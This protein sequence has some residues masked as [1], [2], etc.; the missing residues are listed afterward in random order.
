[1]SNWDNYI[2]LWLQWLCKSV[3]HVFEIFRCV[4][5]HELGKSCILFLMVCLS[6]DPCGVHQSVFVS[7]SGVS[8]GAVNILILFAES[9]VQSPGLRPSDLQ[10]ESR[11]VQ[12]CG[13]SRK[14]DPV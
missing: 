2:T 8:N 7:S 9:A 4:F 5:L 14:V 10:Q 3:T 12:E 13:V 6:S 11:P 1:M